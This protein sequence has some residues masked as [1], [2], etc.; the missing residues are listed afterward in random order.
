MD[1]VEGRPIYENR[2]KAAEALARGLARY[3]GRPDCVVLGLPRGGMPVAYGIARELG[4]ALDVLPVRKLGVPGNGELAFG[5]VAVLDR[6]IV[7]SVGLSESDARAVEDRARRELARRRRAWREDGDPR[8]LDGK[9]AILADDGLAT[10]ATMRAAVRAARERGAERVVVAVP[11]AAEASLEG[12]RSE[13]D[14]IVCPATPEPFLAVGRWYVDFAPTGDH[15]VRELLRRAS[16]RSPPDPNEAAPNDAGI[17]RREVGIECEDG[18]LPGRLAVPA[19]AEGFVVV[20]YGSDGGCGTR[21]REIVPKL[22]GESGFA[23][24]E[25][26]LLTEREAEEEESRRIG[27]SFRIPRLAN[28]LVEVLDGLWTRAGYAERDVSRF[29][30]SAGPVSL[31]ASGTAAAAALSAAALRPKRVA[32]DGC[33]SGRPDLAADALPKVR[34]PVLLVVGERDPSLL[35]WNRTAG[36]GLPSET[37]LLVVP[38]AGHLFEESGTLEESTYAAVGWFRDHRAA[39]SA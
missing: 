10:G 29:G 18:T 4:L 5:A 25:I 21:A 31:L 23:T 39:D 34:A 6:G 33:R 8:R 7:E 32:A 15:E 11:V 19:H 16:D 22:L 27:R 26:D 2:Y 28:R 35:E 13:A 3:R 37:R 30:T 38:G 36:E 1:A 12:I 24:L 9:T 14:E 20:A 17:E